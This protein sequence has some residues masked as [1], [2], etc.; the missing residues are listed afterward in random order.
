MEDDGDDRREMVGDRGRMEG[1]G[2]RG[3]DMLADNNSTA[4]PVLDE[5]ILEKDSQHHNMYLA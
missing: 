5:I 2:E 4:M 1:T 3:G